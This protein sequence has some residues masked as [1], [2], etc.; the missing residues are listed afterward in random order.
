MTVSSME[1]SSNC[2]LDFL[3]YNHDVQIFDH[4]LRSRIIELAAF[5]TREV[6]ET[7]EDFF[8][9]GC[10]TAFDPHVGENLCQIRAVQI[11]DY[12]D[13]LNSDPKSTYGYLEYRIQLKTQLSKLNVIQNTP[14]TPGQTIFMLLE[15]NEIDIVIDQKLFMLT[16]MHFLTKF[17]ICNPFDNTIIDYQKMTSKLNI[18]KNLARR[19]IHDYQK[20]LSKFCCDYVAQFAPQ[21]HPLLPKIL[22]LFRYTDDDA[23]TT[24]P[25]Y[26]V[27]EVLM[28]RLRALQKNILFVVKHTHDESKQFIT[29]FYRYN[30]KT[31]HYELKISPSKQDTAKACLVIHGISCSEDW[32]KVNY[33]ARFEYMGMQQILMSNMA[34]HSQYS[35]KKFASLK[36]N[37]YSP[38]MACSDQE[39]SQ[40]ASDLEA[41]FLEMKRLGL[42]TG[43]L[44]QIPTTLFIR[45]IFTDTAINQLEFAKNQEFYTEQIEKHGALA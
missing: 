38:L 32:I 35:G 19:I 44:E 33:K 13:E 1:T 18:S 24:L 45:H 41:T 42:K 9:K 2:L 14:L 34:T 4:N 12:L 10:L 21:I 8:V 37:P 23:R 36:N 31:E 39:L 27:M 43:C 17:R 5:I 16:L 26:L 11:L 20:K 40:Y 30:Q 28:W 15:S 25:C 29:L 3:P 22:D 6:I 7:I